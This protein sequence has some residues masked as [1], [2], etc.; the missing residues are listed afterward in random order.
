MHRS[1]FGVSIGA[2][3]VACLVVPRAM[4]VVSESV[5]KLSSL[6]RCDFSPRPHPATAAHA[7]ASTQAR[8]IAD[9]VANAGREGK[10][11]QRPLGDPAVLLERR[12]E[13]TVRCTTC[14]ATRDPLLRGL[15][16]E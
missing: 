6:V 16:F 10:P 15:S 4:A 8:L 11:L 9:K 13:A 12:P 5:S 2:A 3:I 1:L 14:L 7:T